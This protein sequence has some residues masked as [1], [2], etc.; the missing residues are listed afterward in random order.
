MNSPVVEAKVTRL[1]QIS[2]ID[3]NLLWAVFW[4]LQK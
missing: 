1:G 3:D 4:W 2:P